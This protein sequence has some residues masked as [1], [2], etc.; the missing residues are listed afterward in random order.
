MIENKELAKTNTQQ[1]AFISNSFIASIV[2]LYPGI[3]SINKANPQIIENKSNVTR[4]VFN[5]RIFADE[6]ILNVR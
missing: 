2:A 5:I 3:F 6:F 1:Y 4:N